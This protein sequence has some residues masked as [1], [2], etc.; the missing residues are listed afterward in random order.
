MHEHARSNVNSRFP[1]QR[2]P[3]ARHHRLQ[4]VCRHHHHLLAI[5]GPGK[6]PWSPSTSRGGI[7]GGLA[8]TLGVILG[9]QVLMW[10]AVAGVAALLTACPDAFCRHAMDRCRLPGLAGFQMLTRQTR[11]RPRAQHHRRPTASSRRCSFTL[12]QPKGHPVSPMAFFPLFAEPG[13][14]PGLPPAF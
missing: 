3:H 13:P 12:A 11:R 7:M 10:S 8:A 1:H 14:Q 5:P 6:Q 4:H 9:D 2:I